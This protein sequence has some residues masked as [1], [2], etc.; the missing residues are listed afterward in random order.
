MPMPTLLDLVKKNGSDAEIGLV[1]ETTREIPEITIV[2]ARDIKGQNFKT[3][4]RTGLPSVSF[5]YA[6]EGVT[7]TKGTVENR[8][9]ETFLLNP[10]WECDKAVADIDEDGPESFIA[11]EGIAMTTAAWQSAASQFYYGVNTDAK[12]FPGLL[13]ALDAAMVVDAGGTTAST[14][15]S[16]WAIRFGRL[17]V[18]WVWGLGAKLELSDVMTARITDANGKPFTAYVQEMLGRPGL[19]VAHKY[20]IGRI[21]KLTE[22]SGKGLTD[23]LIN[24]L[25]EK[26]PAG[27]EPHAYFASKRSIRQLRDSRT[28]TN[29]TGAPAP[30]PTEVDGIPLYPT[31][32]IINTEAL[33][34]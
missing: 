34:L 19:K 4:V 22:D 1:D 18:E 5:R 24:K 33:T 21:K 20:S 25:R 8:L 7:A 26:F 31:E 9:I 30:W 27:R 13:A 23:L 16:L 11:E 15:S 6:N 14:G 29:A 28:A 3:R 12:G 32:A 2:P 17:D 10:R